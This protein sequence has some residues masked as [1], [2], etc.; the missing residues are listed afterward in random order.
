MD[1][2]N[3]ER[4]AKVLALIDSSQP[5]EASAALRLAKQILAREGLSFADLARQAANQSNGGRTD[6]RHLATLGQ[7]QS[8][9]EQRLHNLQSEFSALQDISTHQED[10]IRA[11]REQVKRL[12]ET[13][14]KSREQVGYWRG[15]AQD[16]A[17]KLWNLGKQVEPLQNQIDDDAEPAKTKLAG[18]FKSR[19][20]LARQPRGLWREWL[21]NT[22]SSEAADK[23]PTS[24]DNI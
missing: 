13:V 11:W 6:P 9:L 8:Q 14:N 23:K 18:R 5:G 1:R 16:V 24:S 22:L 10:E 4:L 15:V 21:N 12:Q 17:D 7:S 19:K 20:P 3:H 2:H